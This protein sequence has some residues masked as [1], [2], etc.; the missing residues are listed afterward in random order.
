[1]DDEEDLAIDEDLIRS[2]YPSKRATFDSDIQSIFWVVK[3]KL[4]ENAFFE[5]SDTGNNSLMMYNE[6]IQ[7]MLEYAQEK[8]IISLHSADMLI[9]ESWQNFKVIPSISK[10][11]IEKNFI[12]EHPLFH[13]DKFPFLICSGFEFYILINVKTQHIDEFIEISSCTIRS[14]QAFFFLEEDYG[15]SFHFA[16]N[17]Q[18]ENILE[19]HIWHK[20]ELKHDFTEKLTIY[21][22]LPYSNID[23]KFKQIQ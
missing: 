23:I 5:Q 3:V 11:N 16:R 13:Q 8:M 7:T 18:T 17:H 6:Q 19:Q 4:S 10:G 9:V 1:M 22:Q 12:G 15:Y 21:G 14:Q 2:E 20:M